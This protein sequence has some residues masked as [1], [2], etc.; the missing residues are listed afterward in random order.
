[1][2]N[3]RFGFFVI[4]AF[5]A[6]ASSCGTSGYYASSVYD[7]GIYYRPTAESRAKMVAA[8]E[9][10]REKERQRQYDQYLAKDEEGNLYVVTE[11]MDGETYE[12]RLHK[13]DSPFYNSYAWYG[14]WDDPWYN[15][16]WGSWRY[17]YS[18][19]WRNPWYSASWY[20]YYPYGYYS[21]YYWSGWYDPWYWGVGYAGW[22]GYDRWYHH[23][24]YPGHIAPGP[25][26]R[27]HGRNV[28]YTPRNTATGSGIYRT[29]GVG[30]VNGNRGMYTTRRTSS[31]GSVSTRT[32]TGTVRSS[33]SSRPTRTGSS[34]G[35]SYTRSS[36]SYSSGGSYS[37]GG[38]SGGGSS[39]SSGTSGGSVSGGNH[40]GGGRR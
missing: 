8:Q 3:N 27:D 26:P 1:M 13:F 25:G 29:T 14:Y 16:W 9:A 38:Y 33:G 32:S 5:A 2:K 28:V 6:L 19:W 20:G 23:H 10:Q 36:G 15:P 21:P 35:G 4:L 17:G 30:T 24:Y 22:Y 34:G 39:R 37:G 7:D 18:S 12:S 11:L 40:S 31:G